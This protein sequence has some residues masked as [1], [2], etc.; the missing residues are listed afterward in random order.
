MVHPR[1]RARNHFLAYH[2][3][4]G[5]N[6]TEDQKNLARN[7]TL[8]QLRNKQIL[9]SRGTDHARTVEEI[10]QRFS[11]LS[12]GTDYH[13]VGAF[14]PDKGLKRFLGS[15]SKYDAYIGGLSHR[16]IARH[17]GKIELIAEDQIDMGTTQW[18]GLVCLLGREIE[19]GGVLEALKTGWFATVKEVNKEPARYWRE[20]AKKLTACFRQ[21]NLKHT[22]TV[23]EMKICWMRYEDFPEQPNDS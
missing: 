16:L 3:Q 14:N 20:M 4:P 17:H 19:L 21:K 12:E 15:V 5:A 1:D 9:A 7:S 6:G 10:A 11:N 23:E 8:G 18:N 22:F 2:D 13:I